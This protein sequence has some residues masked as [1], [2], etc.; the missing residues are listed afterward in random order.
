M[1]PLDQARLR[2]GTPWFV[3]DQSASGICRFY[4][5]EVAPNFRLYVTPLNIDPS[6][7][8]VPISEPALL[9]PGHVRAVSGSSP[10]LG[11]QEAYQARKNGRFRGRRIR[12]ASGHGPRGAARPLRLRRENYDDGLLFFYFS[13]SDLQSHMFWWNSDEAHP[14]R[15]DHRGE[16]VLSATSAAYTRGSTRWSATS[17]TATAVRRPSS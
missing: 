10:P 1:E 7:P 8:A 13:S 17:W 5:Q 15:S 11:F 6:A 12:P 4:L 2:L 3:P 14:T 9:R 16:K